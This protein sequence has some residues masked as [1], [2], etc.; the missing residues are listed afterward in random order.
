MLQQ[1]SK[2]LLVVLGIAYINLTILKSSHNKI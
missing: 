1:L 2:M